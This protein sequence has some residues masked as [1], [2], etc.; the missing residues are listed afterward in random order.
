MNMPGEIQI[1][2]LNGLRA[3]IAEDGAVHDCKG[4]LI[5]F[6]NEDGSAGDAYVPYCFLATACSIYVLM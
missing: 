4:V 6:I 1:H 2:G 5:G 3:K